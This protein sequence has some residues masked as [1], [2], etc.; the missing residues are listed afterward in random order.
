M[1]WETTLKFSPKDTQEMIRNY[2]LTNKEKF[3]IV[4]TDKIESID[5]DVNT[6]YEGYGMG[7]YTVTELTGVSVKLKRIQAI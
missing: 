1:E 6:R 3:G 2:I 7:E 5:F 4:S